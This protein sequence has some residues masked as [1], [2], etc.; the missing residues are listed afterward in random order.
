M[1]SAGGQKNAEKMRKN[2]EKMRKNAGFSNGGW[3]KDLEFFGT[4]DHQGMSRI[5]F[6]PQTNDMLRIFLR[7]CAFFPFFFQNSA[8]L[9]IFLTFC[10]KSTFSPFVWF[11]RGHR[12]F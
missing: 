9:R 4:L 2:A 6:L 11:F 5:F 1:R 3:Q 8:F 7:F 12:K 10:Q